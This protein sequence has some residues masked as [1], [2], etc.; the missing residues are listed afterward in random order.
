M[1]V[2]KS[3]DP[4]SSRRAAPPLPPR[5][6]APH[7]DLLEIE[8]LTDLV[9]FLRTKLKAVKAKRVAL[10]RRVRL[11]IAHLNGTHYKN[12]RSGGQIRKDAAGYAEWRARMVAD[13]RV[14]PVMTR[15]QEAIYRR[16]RYRDHYT[17]EDAIREAMR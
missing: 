9:A 11:K 10:Q 3:A 6:A 5:L 16:L 1:S 15:E 13:G 12:G 4:S 8:R 17:R 14:L 2:A 7:S